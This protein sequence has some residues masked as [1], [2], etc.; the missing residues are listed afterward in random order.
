M[1]TTRNSKSQQILPEYYAWSTY[2]CVINVQVL[3]YFF[4]KQGV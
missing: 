2:V 1:D 4:D 3:K